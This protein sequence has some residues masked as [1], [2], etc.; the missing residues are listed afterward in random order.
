MQPDANHPYDGYATMSKYNGKVSGHFTL[1]ESDFAIHDIGEGL[2]VLE[3]IVDETEYICGF[4]A[5]GGDGNGVLQTNTY[6]RTCNPEVRVLV[7]WTESAANSALFSGIDVIANIAIAEANQALKNSLCIP[8]T[9][10][11]YWR[12][13]SCCQVFHRGNGR[14]LVAHDLYPRIGAPIRL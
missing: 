6:E 7:L 14:R 4:Q 5:P 13:S 2:H 1:D 12:I 8:A 10:V 11:S 9:F 3:Q